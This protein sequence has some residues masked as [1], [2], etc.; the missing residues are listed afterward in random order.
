M[1]LPNPNLPPEWLQALAILQQ[2]QQEQL[3]AQQGGLTQAAALQAEPQAGFD[4]R[5]AGLEEAMAAAQARAAQARAAQAEQPALPPLA[6]YGERVL[7]GLPGS[8]PPV[9][10]TLPRVNAAGRWVKNQPWLEPVMG[11]MADAAATIGTPDYRFSDGMA[12][13]LDAVPIAKYGLKAA[14]KV[15]G[16]VVQKAAKWYENMPGRGKVATELATNAA[17]SNPFSRPVSDPVFQR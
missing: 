16:P 13:A 17:V 7:G 8:L 3:A 2:R 14:A 9:P 6:P 10:E 11:G 1:A 12:A 4:D 15:G 5:F